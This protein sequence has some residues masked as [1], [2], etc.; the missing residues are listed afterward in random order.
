MN[1]LITS[2]TSATIKTALEYGDLSVRHALS[3]AE[4]DRVKHILTQASNDPVLN[5]WI[6]QVDYC[7]GYQL[8]LMNP[9]NQADYRI[10]QVTLSKH[11]A[12]LLNEIGQDH[13]P[14]RDQALIDQARRCVQTSI[15]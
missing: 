11:L 12:A 14:E 7:L 10:Q 5:F 9:E 8:G 2:S 3:E 6:D 1:D 4:V 15:E 13:D